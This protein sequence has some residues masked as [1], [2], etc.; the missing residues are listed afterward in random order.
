MMQ[1]ERHKLFHAVRGL[2]RFE[3]RRCGKPGALAQLGERLVCNQEVIG[4]I[5]IRSID[6][7]DRVGRCW[8]VDTR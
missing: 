1:T 8:D 5:P 7:H 4:S 3:S 6:L 2:D